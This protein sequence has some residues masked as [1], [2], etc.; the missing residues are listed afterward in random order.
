[1]RAILALVL[2]IVSCQ[3]SKPNAYKKPTDAKTETSNWQSIYASE[4]AAGADE[5]GLVRMLGDVGD[6]ALFSCLAMVSG[7][8]VFDVGILLRGGKPIRHPLIYHFPNKDAP[9]SRDHMLGI[10]ICLRFYPDKDYALKLITNWIN[11]GR[12]HSVVAGWD[13]C[14]SQ[15]VITFS[16]KRTTWLGQC[17]ATPNV[18]YMIYKVAISLGYKCDNTCRGWMLVAEPAPLDLI[19]YERH[20]QVL[21]IW[22]LGS[23]D[24]A[25]SI[26]ALEVLRKAAEENPHNGLYAGVYALFSSGN[27]ELANKANNDHAYFPD[28]RAPD[29]REFCADYL[30][31][32][33]EMLMNSDGLLVRNPDWLPCPDRPEK[34]GTGRGI[35]RLF[36]DHVTH[37]L[38]S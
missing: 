21:A 6:S 30:F 22:L 35:D 7:A 19:G 18:I 14:T 34:N 25:I 15:D 16:I 29:N 17:L 11:Y 8:A 4:I 10:L 9:I 2:L 28:D 32:R 23:I 33:D 1:M 20:L 31:Q 26:D 12:T 38:G 5:Y 13:M 3:Q 27:M 36:S 24:R 37:G